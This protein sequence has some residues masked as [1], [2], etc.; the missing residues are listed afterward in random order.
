MTRRGL[1]PILP[2]GTMVNVHV[3]FALIRHQTVERF[4]SVMTW[5][6]RGLPIAVELIMLFGSARL[7]ATLM[8]NQ[9]Y[10]ERFPD[11]YAWLTSHGAPFEYE[12][13]WG[14]FAGGAA[15]LKVVGL[16]L[17]LIY[18]RDPVM[19]DLGYGMRLFGW[20]ASCLVWGAFSISLTVWDPLSYAAIASSCAL[21][22][23]LWG[24]LMGPAMP[25]EDLA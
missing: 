12:W 21:A 14:L 23:A 3:T 22:L 11:A 5:F 17:C 16:A 9:N 15:L 19:A 10:F 18:R 24:L 7:A 2:V 8:A 1:F 6:R 20:L 13:F 4:G 25:D